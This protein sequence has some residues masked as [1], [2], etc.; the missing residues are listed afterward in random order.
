MKLRS[1]LLRLSLVV[2][3]RWSKSKGPTRRYSARLTS[4]L[5][6]RCVDWWSLS[7]LPMALSGRT[8]VRVVGRPFI[9]SLRI[10][11]QNLDCI[12][13]F[14]AS[15]S[16]GHATKNLQRYMPWSRMAIRFEFAKSTWVRSQVGLAEFALLNLM[17]KSLPPESSMD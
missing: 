15:K 14:L 3:R 11:G 2:D 13:G 8:A 16:W 1:N 6:Q 10:S 5:I 17:K 4:S 9:S 12:A 7:H